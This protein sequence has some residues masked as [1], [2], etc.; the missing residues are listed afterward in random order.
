VT[1]ILR[2]FRDRVQPKAAGVSADELRRLEEMDR[3]ADI[4]YGRAEQQPSESRLVLVETVHNADPAR[5]CLQVKTWVSSY[6]SAINCPR[7]LHVMGQP[8]A[9]R[10]LVERHV[11][12]MLG[13]P[14]RQPAARRRKGKGR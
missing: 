3:F 5:A 6:V 10:Q 1:D 11:A 4:V 13:R 12:A 2:S 7:C 14:R 9:M 8:S